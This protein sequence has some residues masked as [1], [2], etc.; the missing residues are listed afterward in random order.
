MATA[1]PLR[2]FPTAIESSFIW[3]RTQLQNGVELIDTS[4]SN[5]AAHLDANSL[6]TVQCQL[7]AH[8][9]CQP[10]RRLLLL[11]YASFQERLSNR[12]ARN[13]AA[14]EDASDDLVKPGAP[15]VLRSRD[16]IQRD[17]FQDTSGSALQEEDEDERSP[18]V[19]RK[20]V[21]ID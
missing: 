6:I 14:S 8:A 10:L 3:Q 11:T 18:L 2:Q 13:A 4:G 19:D 17:Q 1:L 20:G 5:H 16:Q 9:R 7:N 15:P 12:A 21:M